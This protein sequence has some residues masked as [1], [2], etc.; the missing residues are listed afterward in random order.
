[1]YQ[2]CFTIGGKRHCFDVPL[3]ID[4]NLIHRPPPPNYPA[5]DLAATVVLLTDAVPQSELSKQLRE[6]ATNFIQQVKKQLPKDVELVES[7]EHA[8]QAA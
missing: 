3:L 8:S 6:I 5:F 1:M 2:F 4:K 7:K